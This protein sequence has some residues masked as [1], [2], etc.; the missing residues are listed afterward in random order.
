MFFSRKKERT[1]TF[2]T[3]VWEKDWKQILLSKDYL[4]KLQIENHQH[5]FSEKILIINNVSDYGPVVHAAEQKIEKGILTNYYIAKDYAKKIFSF[6]KLKRE[7]FK[8]DMFFDGTDDWLYYNALAP[9]T[10]IYFCRSDYLLYHTGDT[11]LKEPVSWIDRAIGLLEKRD[12]IK[13]ANLTW[14]EKYIEANK[15]SYRET[16]DFYLSK[17]GFSDQLFLV[18]TKDFQK[19]I[20]QTIRED[21]SHFPRGDVFEKRVFCHMLEAG[22]KRITFKKGSY[23]HENF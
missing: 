19:P 3:A 9:L 15:E 12:K 18:K 23:T 21:A 4:Q 20:Y 10:S 17:R 1:V 2:A 14:N 8:K 16:K 7:D 6:F 11:Y 5:P 13:V 22:W